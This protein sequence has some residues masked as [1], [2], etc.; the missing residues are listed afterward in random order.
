M[1]QHVIDVFFR[2]SLLLA[3]AS[4]NVRLPIGMYLL[5]DMFELSSLSPF[6]SK[7]ISFPITGQSFVCGVTSNMSVIDMLVV[8]VSS[9]ANRLKQ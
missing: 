6:S 1:G 7:S 8:S 4:K 9:L 2:A 3:L 5:F